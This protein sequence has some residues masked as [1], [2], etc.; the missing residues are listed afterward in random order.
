MGNYFSRCME[1]YYFIEHNT[2]IDTDTDINDLRIE[3]YTKERYVSISQIK[4]I[5]NY[6][7]GIWFNNNS[8][9]TY[10]CRIYGPIQFKIFYGDEENSLLDMKTHPRIRF[11]LEHDIVRRSDQEPLN[12]E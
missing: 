3:Y 5:L 2:D 10:I 7:K 12:F 1:E 6:R 9:E 4:D 11:I 8:E